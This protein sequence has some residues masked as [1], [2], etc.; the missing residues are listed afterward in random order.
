MKK[1][2]LLTIAMLMMHATY[3]QWKPDVQLTT[4]PASG[5]TMGNAAAPNNVWC[6]AAD[7]NNV[8]VV[9]YE[10]RGGNYEIFYNRSVDGGVTWAGEMAITTKATVVEAPAIAVS[11]Q[12]VHVAWQDMRNTGYEIYY[13]H[14]TDGGVT[15]QATDTRITTNTGTF[16]WHPC[17]AVSGS[18]VHIV[19]QD[20][21]PG[22]WDILYNRSTDGGTTW[23]PTH[24]PLTTAAT[25]SFNPVIAVNG[26][27][28]HV[29]WQDNVNGNWDI[30]YAHSANT[31]VTW[32][33][34]NTQ[35]TTA[36]TDEWYPSI[37]VAGNKVHL[38]WRDERNGPAGNYDVYY[39]RSTDGGTTWQTTDYQLTN[40]VNG[41]H[42]PSIAVCDSSVH[43]VW[44][45]NRITGNWEVFYTR[46]TDHGVTWPTVITQL[47]NA[48]GDSWHP[49]VA[50]SG[51]GVHIVWSD[52][53]PGSGGYDVYCKSDPTGCGCPCGKP[54]GLENDA[55][56]YAP[57][58]NVY[59]NPAKDI[60]N[61][62][63]PIAI[64]V[65]VSSMDGKKIMQVNDVHSIDISILAQGLYILY[66]TDNNDRLIKK[67]KFVKVQ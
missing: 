4:D 7:G 55:L 50:A 11:G 27:D 57:H 14:S 19:W 33:G 28:V 43:V 66:I 13:N 56:A 60:V 3:A 62:T 15:W 51:L 22:N 42:H 67:E 46:S 12:N 6:V 45:D 31:G 16:S 36:T 44:Y 59:P 53:R 41:S 49:S 58:I 40:D 18:D 61:I 17:V 65:T 26:T 23:Q 30:Y 10:N 63:S 5:F 37:A 29:A 35:I 52:N 8:H 47:T 20:N 2:F 38:V 32:P 24:T 34:A 48:A 9:W 25:N 1:A 21:T 54:A 39:N 64:N